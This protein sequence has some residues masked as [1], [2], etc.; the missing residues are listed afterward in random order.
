MANVNPFPSK[1]N[2]STKTHVSTESGGL[3]PILGYPNALFS[4]GQGGPLSAPRV[5]TNNNPEFTGQPFV[6]TI[7]LN[8]LSDDTQKKYAEGDCIFLYKPNRG[9]SEQTYTGY[10]I[11]N[12][13]YY[14][15]M[16]YVKSKLPI[17]QEIVNG[18]KRPSSALDRLDD[19]PVTI[20]QFQENL[21]H[22]GFFDSYT[23]KVKVRKR[24]C[25]LTVKGEVKRFPN[26][27]A[28]DER[29]DT[30]SVGD[31]IALLVTMVENTQ[32]GRLNM[33][34]KVEA[35]GTLGKF[36]Q[37]KGIWEHGSHHAIG[38]TRTGDPRE[39]DVDFVADVTIPQLTADID[40][41]THLVLN[42]TAKPS[43]KQPFMTSSV[44]RQGLVIPLGRIIRVNKPP[45][46]HDID[47]A[48]RSY[49]G[50]ATLQKYSTIDFWYNPLPAYR[51][52]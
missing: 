47:M 2:D 46:K 38:C 14:L 31:T 35:P 27:F 50:W 42:G 5:V 51:L 9:I 16:A 30:V 29:G 23:D 37:V 26:I 19:F 39:G 15:E 49:T 28:P 8:A 4:R 44:Y 33:D 11:W 22:F 6:S 45:S 40:P 12:L 20:E 34:G 52:V 17:V 1:F 32:P 21:H 41:N 10:S 48:L 7:K 3:N 24:T 25:G 36:L 13:N 18:R 43:A